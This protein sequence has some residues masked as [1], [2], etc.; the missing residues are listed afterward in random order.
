MQPAINMAIP[1]LPLKNTPAHTKQE[2]TTVHKLFV[3]L[4]Q[5]RLDTNVGTH[6]PTSL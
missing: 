5:Y 3:V 4:L 2:Q 6:S 1:Q